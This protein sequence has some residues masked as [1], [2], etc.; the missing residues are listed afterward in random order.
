MLVSTLELSILFFIKN[1]KICVLN[2]KSNQKYLELLKDLEFVILLLYGTWIYQ[3]GFN[4]DNFCHVLIL[5]L[6]GTSGLANRV[7]QYNC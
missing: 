3:S 5:L 7:I 6:V 1:N 4:I 2:L